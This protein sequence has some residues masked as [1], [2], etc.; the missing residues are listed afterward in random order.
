VGQIRYLVFQVWNF[1]GAHY[2]LTFLS[3]EEDPLSGEAKTHAMRSRYYA[4]STGRLC[5][6]MRQAGF[7]DVRRIDEAFYQPVLVGTRAR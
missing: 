4:V 7:S 6:L 2:D 3:V 1:E 5:E